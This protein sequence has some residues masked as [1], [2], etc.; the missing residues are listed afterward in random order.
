MSNLVSKKIADM[1]KK[2]LIKECLKNPEKPISHAVGDSEEIQAHPLIKDGELKGFNMFVSDVNDSLR[3]FDDPFDDGTKD[4][5]FLSVD[6]YIKFSEKLKKEMIEAIK[7]QIKD[8]ANEWLDEGSK[9]GES[10]NK[11]ARSIDKKLGTHLEEKELGK[12]LK[13]VEKFVSDK[14]LGKIND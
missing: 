4:N 7:E 12:S 1:K 14:L 11:F 3:P 6:E 9:L 5:N 13:M 8:A 2:S 10:R